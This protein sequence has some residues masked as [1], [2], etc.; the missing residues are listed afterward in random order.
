M[1]TF[2]PNTLIL[3]IGDVLF[4]WSL[5]ATT[6]IAPQRFRRMLSSMTWYNYERGRISQQ[7]CFASLS[8]EFSIGFEV[9]E[10][11]ITQARDTLEVNNELVACIREL[12][13]QKGQLRVY[14]MSNISLPDYEYLRKKPMDWSIFDEVFTSAEV[15]ERKPNLSFYRH[16]MS[17]ANIDPH[18]A[19]FV[20]DNLDNVLSARSLGFHGIV[21]D[22]SQN[23]IRSLRNIFFDP[24]SRGREFLSR[25]AHNQF[26][27]TNTGV[28][29]RENFALLLILEATQ[30]EYAHFPQTQPYH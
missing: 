24:T 28:M 16:V 30:D 1:C 5:P 3:D 20:D 6:G 12:K 13:R 25:H 26:S 4:S 7:E 29:L 10:S 21:F 8:N 23:V 14:A 15:G 27:V 18:Q 22:D 19:I 2:T 11:A 9:V 17:K